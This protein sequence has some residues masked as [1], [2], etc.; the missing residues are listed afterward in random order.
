MKTTKQ[1]VLDECRARMAS[2]HGGSYGSNIEQKAMNS[3]IA[4]LIGPN[5]D[6]AYL[7]QC[8]MAILSACNVLEKS[9]P[10][11]FKADKHWP[12]PGHVAADAIPETGTVIEVGTLIAAQASRLD[13]LER[14]FD[15]HDHKAVLSNG[16]IVEWDDF[17]LKSQIGS[18][19]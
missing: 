12:M 13:A 3:I 8:H 11:D 6:T 7:L 1:M 15:S 9:L 17:V 14:R 19:Q 5:P 10:D 2:L 16:K 18:D 4:H